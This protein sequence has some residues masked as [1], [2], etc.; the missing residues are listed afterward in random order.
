MTGKLCDETF[1]KHPKG[2]LCVMPFQLW[3]V[4]TVNEKLLCL[5]KYLFVKSNLKAV[6]N[7]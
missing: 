1:Q 2:Q 4:S 5:F 3:F 6:I 7:V